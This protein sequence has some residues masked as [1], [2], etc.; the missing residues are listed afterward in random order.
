[1][2]LKELLEPD[3]AS[4]GEERLVAEARLT[5]RL[6][7]PSIVPVYD[8]GRWPS[9][10][11]FYVMKFVAGPSLASVVAGLPTLAARLALLPRVIAVVEAIA[12]AHGERI[13]H[14]DLKPASILLGPFGET[15]VIGWGLARDLAST[16]DGGR[17]EDGPTED[18]PADERTDIQALGA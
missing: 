8:A 10:K 6:Q 5:A 1:V 13:I 4:G 14:G 12:H 7:H 16:Q 18:S 15:V 17:P 11:P 2:A 9:G 3:A